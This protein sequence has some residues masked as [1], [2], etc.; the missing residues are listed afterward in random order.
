[1]LFGQT[2]NLGLISNKFSFA[3]KN[4]KVFTSYERVVQNI[5]VVDILYLD[6]ISFY[7]SPHYRKF[8]T[9]RV[10]NIAGLRPLRVLYDTRKGTIEPNHGSNSSESA[11]V[12][13]FLVK[14]IYFMSIL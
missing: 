5:W 12:D 3:F 4:F 11:T 1:M 2:E 13:S 9:S 7:F 10:M 14:K 8:P 6:N